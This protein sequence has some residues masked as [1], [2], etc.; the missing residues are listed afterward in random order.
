MRAPAFA[1]KAGSIAISSRRGRTRNAAPSAA[2]NRGRAPL[3]SA[4]VRTNSLMPAVSIV[5]AWLLR[6]DERTHG[7]RPATGVEHGCYA[8]AQGEQCG[9]RRMGNPAEIAGFFD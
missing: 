7:E 8:A 1:F 3:G 2:I 6:H 5:S 4:S 9:T